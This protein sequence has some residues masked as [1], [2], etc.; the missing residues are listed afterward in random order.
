ML[1]KIKPMLK[2]IKG[3]KG[4]QLKE[5]DIMEIIEEQ[6]HKGIIEEKE[7]DDINVL[8]NKINWKVR[9][10]EYEASKK[11]YYLLH[12]TTYNGK[13]YNFNDSN[14]FVTLNRIGLPSNFYGGN[15]YKVA[16]CDMTEEHNVFLLI[17]FGNR[18]FDI[19]KFY[20]NPLKEI[21]FKEENK[22]EITE[23]LIDKHHKGGGYYEYQGETKRGKESFIRF[24]IETGDFKK[25]G[26]LNA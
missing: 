11:D 20:R 24:L 21:V 8:A 3:M 26:E 22:K 13:K 7:L 6:Y 17:E 5:K 18:V 19:I 9:V 12:S 1:E 14:G 15:V 25:G 4:I 23:A 10:K 16:K 2:Q